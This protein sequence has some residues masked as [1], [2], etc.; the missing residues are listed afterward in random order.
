MLWPFHLGDGKWAVTVARLPK[1]GSG[2]Y[3]GGPDQRDTLPGEYDSEED[4]LKAGDDYAVA[5]R[6]GF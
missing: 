6:V 1:A 4:A 3:F 2:A 5:H